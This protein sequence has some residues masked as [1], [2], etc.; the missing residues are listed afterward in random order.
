MLLL[1][2]PMIVLACGPFF[3]YVTT[4]LRRRPAGVCRGCIRDTEKGKRVSHRSKRWT[5]LRNAADPECRIRARHININE[6]IAIIM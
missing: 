4:G 5:P 2:T 6:G 1:L 3:V